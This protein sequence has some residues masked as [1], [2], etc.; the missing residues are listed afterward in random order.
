MDNEL[1]LTDK[2]VTYE[3]GS[4]DF[5]DYEQL[6]K[7][8]LK[9][10]DSVEGVEVTP[11]TVAINKKLR[12]SINKEVQALKSKRTQIKRDMLT[13][14]T[15]FST[16]VDEIINIVDGANLKVDAQIKS[17]EEHDRVQKLID[18]TKMFDLHAQGYEN[19]P[20][21][22]KFFITQHPEVVNKSYSMSKVEVDIAQWL[23][24]AQSDIKVIGAQDNSSEVLVVYK[25][26]GCDLGKAIE[27][28]SELARLKQ[29]A[30]KALELSHKSNETKVTTEQFIYVLSSSKD[31]KML[32][33]FM[34]QNN[35]AYTKTTQ[36]ENK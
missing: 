33:M 34:E 7:S 10:A 21:N 2:S 12:A 22:A 4:V 5:V 29:E 30:K 26:N 31:A 3:L 16:Q 13:P 28:V 24:H 1:T 19:F 27:E 20:M 23:E 32:E 9:L 8:A 17:L 35:I 18:V 14:F 11:K 25:R 6:K 15:P 36:K